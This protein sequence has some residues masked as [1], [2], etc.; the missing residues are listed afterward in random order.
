MPKKKLA[1]F[2]S[3]SMG[4]ALIADLVAA[5]FLA[6]EHRPFVALVASATAT[7]PG[8]VIAVLAWQGKLQTRCGSQG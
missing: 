5:L 2:L 4:A 8:F 7:I 6:N 3:A 1:V